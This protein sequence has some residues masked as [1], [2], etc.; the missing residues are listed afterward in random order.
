VNISTDRPDPGRAILAT[1]RGLPATAPTACT[2]WTAHHVAAH[3]AAGSRE[4]ADLTE[5]RAAGR[6]PRPTRAFE[7]RERP[8]RAMPYADVLDEMAVQ[9]RRKLT[10]Y[11]ALV[12][13]SDES[14]IDFTGTAITV[15]ELTT[16]S[17]SEAALHR[18]DLVGDDPH[19]DELLADP[20][21]T[22]HA[23]KILNRMPELSESARSIAA[24][25][26]PHGRPRIVLRAP[27]SPDVGLDTAGHGKAGLAAADSLDGDLVI[28]TDPAHRLLVLWG[29]RSTQRA[30]DIDGPG[31]LTAAASAIVW[32]DAQPWPPRADTS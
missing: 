15:D 11:E 14:A 29:R 4:I 7:E 23:V 25:A 6:P 17:R 5:D 20:E 26:A 30:V 9:T 10:A 12:E 8:Y 19:A 16:H 24:R 22:A 31:E 1:L 21:L 32:P 13:A 28:T 27:G 18:W 3:L 2:G